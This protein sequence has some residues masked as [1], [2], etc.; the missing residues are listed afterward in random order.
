MEGTLEIFWFKKV[1]VF[2]RFWV[3]HVFDITCITCFWYVHSD[4]EETRKLF[5]KYK[6]T[7]VI[8]LAAMVGGL[9]HN[10]AHNLDF[11]VCKQAELNRLLSC[12]KYDKFN[13]L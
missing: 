10:M 12:I 5:D 1:S 2:S 9:F 3:K 8:H 4:N 13:N 6:P 11:L 7:H